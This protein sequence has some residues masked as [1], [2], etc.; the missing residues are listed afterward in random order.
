MAI[1]CSAAKKRHASLVAMESQ[2]EFIDVLDNDCLLEPSLDSGEQCKK[3]K[4]H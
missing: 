2:L 3:K 4:K 1:V